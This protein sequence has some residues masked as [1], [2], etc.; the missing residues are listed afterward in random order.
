MFMLDAFLDGATGTGL[1]GKLRW[2]G[3]PTEFID[4]RSTAEFDAKSEARSFDTKRRSIV[5]GP[6]VAERFVDIHSGKLHRA[7]KD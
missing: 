6:V 5:S 4:S 7:N 1:F 2:P 3:A